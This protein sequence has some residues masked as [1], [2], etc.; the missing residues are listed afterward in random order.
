[1]AAVYTAKE[2]S[3]FNTAGKF[4]IYRETKNSNKSNDQYMVHSNPVFKA[5]LQHDKCDNQPHP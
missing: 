3:H 5:I 4:N 1:M 2:G